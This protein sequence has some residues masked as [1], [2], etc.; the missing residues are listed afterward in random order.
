MEGKAVPFTFNPPV[1][2]EAWMKVVVSN[3]T[4]AAS[5]TGDDKQKDY[6]CQKYFDGKIDD[7]DYDYLRKIDDYEM[8]AKV[9]FIPI[10]R[11]N[12]NHLISLESRRS[13]NYKVYASDK[14][15]LKGRLDKES[16]DLIRIIDQN[17]QNK[18]LMLQAQQQRMDQQKEQLR[19]MLQQEPSNQQEQTQMQS[20]K[21]MMPML[22][23]EI[24][25]A[26]IGM[27]R[28][29]YISKKEI[30]RVEKYYKYDYNDFI[31]QKAQ[32]L[33]KFGAESTEVGIKNASVNGFR[34]KMVTGKEVYFV[35]LPKGNKYPVFKRFH[36]YNVYWSGDGEN[37]WIQD[38][39]WAAIR[40]K[41]AASSVIDWFGQHLTNNDMNRIS[42]WNAS[43]NYQSMTTSINNGAVF[44]NNNKDLY[45][46]TK[47][48]KGIDVWFTY[49]KSPRKISVKHTPNKYQ[50]GR[51]HKHFADEGQ[52]F[53]VNKEKGE[54]IID[55]WVDD[56]YEGVQIGQNPGIFVNMGRMCV[57]QRSSNDFS[58]KLPIYGKSFNGIESPYS[59]VWATKDIQELFNIVHYHRELMLALAGVKGIVMDMAQ[60]PD[61]YTEKEWLYYRKQGITFIN[62]L[63]RTHG[64]LPA[65][66]QFQ[67][68]DDSVSSSIQY[69]DNILL[70]LQRLVDEITAVPYQRKGQTAK[71]DQVGTTQNAVEQSSLTTEILYYEHDEVIRRALEGWINLAKVAAEKGDVVTYMN[72][73]GGREIVDIPG[74]IFKNKQFEMHVVNTSKEEEGLRDLKQLAVQG[75]GQGSLDLGQLA[76]VYTI[77]NLKEL[78]KTLEGYAE[79]AAENAQLYEQN[80]IEAE[81]QAELEK[82]KFEKDYEKAIADQQAQLKE[83]ELG[84]KKAEVAI[85]ERELAIKEAIEAQKNQ[86]K[87]K[88]IVT[89]REVE[90][91]YLAEQNRASRIEEMLNAIQIQLDAFFQNRQLDMGHVETMKK[92]EVDKLKAKQSNKEKIKN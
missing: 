41:M 22:M 7:S 29:V 51:F 65:F 63:K 23:A 25:A 59:L 87:D 3:I 52:E 46:G 40:F 15:S 6:F 32:G 86:L 47:L 16:L 31:E 56:V 18:S 27:E 82:I 8:P 35:D 55:R 90:M 66:N 88:E 73:D 67:T 45:G 60:K 43:I 92:L 11:Q 62:S 17:M 1:K 30:E 19:L 24:D 57:Q 26:K 42:R 28:E 85:K 58:V 81:K 21:D 89:E 84:I 48:N 77:E 68:Y 79:R 36:P 39:Q 91:N 80:K 54:F 50:E 12:L 69:L 64:K 33:V 13:F 74:E 75:Y 34:D 14:D 20:L 4:M 10:V 49:W 61:E 83:V 5:S 2:T 38:G 76:K 53:R 71:T 78:Q 72:Q 9:R 37:E 44:A 70:S